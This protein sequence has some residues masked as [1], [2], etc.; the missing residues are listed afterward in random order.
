MKLIITLLVLTFVTG[1]SVNK[2]DKNTIISSASESIEIQSCIDSLA[3]KDLGSTEN[4][5]NYPIYQ[6]IYDSYIFDPPFYCANHCLSTD[7][8]CCETRIVRNPIHEI[9]NK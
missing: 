2:Y 9:E 5:T 3:E 4:F 8:H 6:R 7:T 1:S